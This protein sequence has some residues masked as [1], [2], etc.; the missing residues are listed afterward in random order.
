MDRGV[1]CVRCGA[2]GAVAALLTFAN[3][4]MAQTEDDPIDR[5][6]ALV[7]A[8][9]TE[10]AD[11]L[12]SFFSNERVEA[13]ANLTRLRA[14]GGVGWAED[15]GFSL[16]GR[17]DL[18]LSLPRTSRRLS[19]FVSGKEDE[20][21]KR[22]PQPSQVAEPLT[23]E[24]TVET[25]GLGLRYF[26]FRGPDNTL[27]VDAGVRDAFPSDYFVEPRHRITFRDG[28]WA[29]SPI[30]EARWSHHDGYS[31]TGLFDVDHT[32]KDNRIMRLTPSI[33]WAET[34]S[35]F[36]YGVTFRDLQFVGPEKALE[37]GA[38]VHFRSEPEHRVETVEIR[39]RY[40]QTLYWN[41]LEL[42][43]APEMT[44]PRT[45][46]YEATPGIFV[47]LELTL[48]HEDVGLKWSE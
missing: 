16:E 2:L 43:V 48:G 28:D 36:G 23:E 6:V 22:T 26:V 5:S 12:D 18:R 20:F 25:I 15:D 19:L 34:L 32:V 42:E 17:F 3:A 29:F 46:D 37:T 10:L 33:S 39:V 35:G 4:S 41:W 30:Q 14:T 40:R 11:R 24:D 38:G 21:A 8:Q 44:F 45:R 7:G 47:R 9:I 1:H 27:R 31:A 13:E